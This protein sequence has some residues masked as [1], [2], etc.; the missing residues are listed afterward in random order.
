MPEPA[1]VER[2]LWND[3]RPILDQELSRLPEI[4]RA[5]IVL[6]DLEGKTR[7]E[8]A[9]HLGL[10]EG[11]VASR[12]ARARALLAKRLT[13]RGVALSAGSLAAA[14]AQNELSSA[15]PDSV[16]ADTLRAAIV[17]AAGRPA[18]GAIS[19]AVAALA[20]GVMKAM[21]MS[22]LKT[23]VAVA[24]GLG[25]IVT[26]AAIFAHGPAPSPVPTA[27]PVSGATVSNLG[28]AVA[29]V[30]G[31]RPNRPIVVRQ[32]ATLGRM[33]LSTDGEVV[34]TVGIVRDGDTAN[35]TVKLWDARTGELKWTLAEEKCVPEIAFSR[36]FLA[37]GLDTPREVRLLDAKTLELKHRIT[38]N[39]VPDLFGWP[40][41]P[42]PLA[43]SPDGK[44][45]AL[46]GSTYSDKFVPFLKLWD[47]EKQRLV[48]GNAGVGEV[49]NDLYSIGCLGFSPDGNILVASWNDARIRLFDGHT[50]AFRSILETNL[51]PNSTYPRE[52]A[53]SPD[54]KTLVSRADDYKTLVMWDLGTGKPRRKL[55]GHTAPIESLAFS[56]DGRWIASGGRTTTFGVYEVILWDAET[57][58]V[59]HT[60]PGLP[61]PPY[62]VAFSP[63]CKTLFVCGGT[64]REGPYTS[65][66]LSSV[67]SGALWLFPLE[68]LIATRAVGGPRLSLAPRE[69][70]PVP[71]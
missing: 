8:A 61:E 57:G 27:E 25:F 11:T 39:H 9:E 56:S 48:E 12:L 6:C 36:D 26:G 68:E 66:G 28:P 17:F 19:P 49:S 54:S 64:G 33:A 70:W 31:A 67:H 62:A 14:L 4:Y 43:F 29:P 3:L 44:R 50:G 65:R 15:A 71:R 35:G 10:P 30:P 45:L 13:G 2:D 5:A 16:M 23:V 51:A 60:I 55:N 38:G 40:S 69:R 34:A 42:L 47:V 46:A 22:K 18:A 58:K 24:L 52:L 37:V 1:A 53:F 63:D 41:D 20:G 7:K 21:S 32:D 59:K